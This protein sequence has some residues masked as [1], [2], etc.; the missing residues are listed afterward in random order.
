LGVQ[1]VTGVT[2]GLFAFRLIH[3]TQP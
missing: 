2:A 1:T 3:P